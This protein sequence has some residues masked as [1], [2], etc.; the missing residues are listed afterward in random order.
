M[1]HVVVI[2]AGL[3]G[4]PAAYELRHLLPTRHQVTLISEQSK[5]TFIPGLIRVALDLKPLSHVQLDLPKLA[6]RHGLN[7]IPSRVTQFDPHNQRITT[8]DGQ[9]LQYDY[10]VIAT[11]ASLNLAAIPGLGP[12]GGYSHSVCTPE[13]ALQARQGWL[14]FLE[15]PGSLVVGAAPEAGCFGPAYEFI[16]MADWE[17]RRRGLRD[18]A[19]LTYIT[20]EPYTGHLGVGGVK[21]A[22]ELTVSLL[23]ERGIKTLDNTRIAEVHPNRITLGNG[24]HIFSDYAMILPSFLG[25]KFI[26]DIPQ[27]GTEKGFIPVTPTYHH[28]KF[29]QIYAVGVSVHLTQ[30]EKTPI[31][32]GLPKSGEMAEAMAV[33]VAHNIAIELG[34]IQA[35]P[36]TPTLEALCFAEFG[37]TGIAYMA[38][39]VIPDPTTGQRRY[40][41]ALKGPWVNWTKAIFEEYFMLKMRFGMGL[42]WFEKLGLQLLFGVSLVKHLSPQ[43]QQELRSAISG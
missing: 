35:K 43:E 1:A 25:A 22:R 17:L 42:P 39:P 29:P 4:L 13:H 41:T 30:P 23:E 10:V 20:P 32:M 40:S 24:Q 3:G 18:K 7:F 15:N 34:I 16:L 8:A 5:F 38:V 37:N 19:T 9:T 14:K 11:G 27:L 26:R 21:N 28:P 31:P 6:R 36:T 12:H 33:A 2:G